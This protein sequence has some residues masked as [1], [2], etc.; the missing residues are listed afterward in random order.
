MKNVTFL[1]L[2]VLLLVSCEKEIN[3]N[4]ATLKAPITKTS[5]TILEQL[6]NPSKDYVLVVSHRGDW[7]YAPENSLQAVKRCIDLGVDIMELDVRLTKDGHLVAIHDETVDRTTNGLGKVSDFTLTEIKKLRLMNACGIPGSIQQIPTLE[8]VMILAKDKIMINLDKTEGKT[9]REAYEILK[10]TGTVNQ[11]IFKG[12]DTY[13]VMYEKYGNLMDSIIYMPKLWYKDE[14]IATYIQTF[15]KTINPFAYEILFDSEEAE[16]YKIIPEIQNQKDTFLAIA[17][18]D[19]LCA[20]H[21]DEQALLE[22]A[23]AAWG[24]LIKNGA[25]AIMTDR[26]KELIEYLKGKGLRN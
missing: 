23:D 8:E 18:W 9:V 12:N 21:T 14:N 16:T 17:L 5:K 1:I 22:G 19:E 6:K 15:E 10:K 7:R 3:G 20:G 26:P 25:N 13:Q 4:A 2:I 11:A 24:W